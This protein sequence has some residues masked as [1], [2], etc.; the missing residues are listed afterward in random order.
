M[1][2]S[3]KDAQIF[4]RELYFGFIE[5]QRQ[6]AAQGNSFAA[7]VVGAHERGGMKAVKKM[8]EQTR[9]AFEPQ[10]EN[11][12]AAREWLSGQLDEAERQV[13]PVPGNVVKFA[14]KQALSSADRYVSRRDMLQASLFGTA[15]VMTAL[16][17][18]GLEDAFDLYLT[19]CAP[20]GRN[21]Q[22]ETMAGAI[23]DPRQKDALRNSMVREKQLQ[24]RHVFTETDDKMTTEKG[25]GMA[26]SALL[27]ILATRS[28]F[29][30]K[31]GA[32][33]DVTVTMPGGASLTRR[34]SLLEAVAGKLNEEIPGVLH[35]AE[36]MLRRPD[37]RQ[38]T[39]ERPHRG[40]HT[41]RSGET[42][43]V[44]APLGR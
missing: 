8:L 5:M 44:G 23:G 35:E 17:A 38:S 30:A 39:P 27:A 3:S 36:Q 15:A 37:I 2:H 43:A 7:A 24:E 14:R 18:S 21:D 34:V 1:R 28:A 25:I 6:N 10:N 16:E 12:Q 26:A 29:S 31:N 41:G 33:R 4:D 20:G 9:A 42:P 32:M 19:N 22:L 13:L 40:M 11:R